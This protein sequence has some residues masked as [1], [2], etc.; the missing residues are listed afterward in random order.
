MGKMRKILLAGLVVIAATP[1][2]EAKDSFL[3]SFYRTMSNIDRNLCATFQSSNC[4][5]KSKPRTVSAVPVQ[6]VTRT[7][8]AAPT[9][10][11][12]EVQDEQTIVPAMPAQ[13]VILQTPSATS[14]PV[15]DATGPACLQN[16]SSAGAK[17][18]AASVET[19]Q[20]SCRVDTPVR[21]MAVEFAGGKV[22]F[23][24]LPVLNCS[25]ALEFSQWVS[26]RAERAVENSAGSK[27]KWIST[28]PGFDCRNRNRD[29]TQKLSEHAKGNAVDISQFMLTNGSAMKVREITNPNG[30][31]F[32]TLKSLRVSA[33]EDFTT[34][35]G[36]GS[37]RAHAEHFHLDLAARKNGYRICQ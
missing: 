13:T 23:P 10:T 1:A 35:L 28:G 22:T 36:P 14:R 6:R 33:C 32:D 30:T 17:F 18:V 27:L 7:V 5:N 8:K 26:Q 9:Y 3:G 20:A 16:L 31:D 11:E 21:L 4:K 2:A 25:F 19:G 24:D 29:S 15:I 34:V 12:P 37:D